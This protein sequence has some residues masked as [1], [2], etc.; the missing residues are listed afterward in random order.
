MK[1][2]DSIKLNKGVH[3]SIVARW[4]SNDG[5]SIDRCNTNTISYEAADVLAEAYGGDQSRIP[6]YI[7]F[8]YGSSGDITV[9]D[10]TRSMSWDKLTDEVE[11]MHANILVQRFS[12]KPDV[13]INDPDNTKEYFGNAVSFHA[14]TRSGAGGTYAFDTSGEYNFATEFGDG[15][16]IYQAVL[17]GDSRNPCSKTNPYSV[18]G[19]VS[20][21]KGGVFRQKPENYELSV[22]WTVSFF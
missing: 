12:R 6:K 13:S 20:M 18:L 9:P 19:R 22:D 2:E 14:I 16:Y 11:L 17:L 15:S 4:I 10:I 3:G 8:I 7:G 21:A 5:S 1:T